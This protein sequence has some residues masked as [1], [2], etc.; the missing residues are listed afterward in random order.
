MPQ[1]KYQRAYGIRRTWAD[2][3]ERMAQALRDND[4]ELYSILD[5]RLTRW[6]SRIVDQHDRARGLR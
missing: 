3:L 5:Q 2:N 1:T 6:A 4:I